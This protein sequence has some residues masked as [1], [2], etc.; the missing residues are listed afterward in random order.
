MQLRI[1]TMVQLYIRST[2][3]LC[4]WGSRLRRWLF[5]YLNVSL[6][7][8][9]DTE[10]ADNMSPWRLI[11]YWLLYSLIDAAF[12]CIGALHCSIYENKSSSAV[13]MI[14]KGLEM[15]IF[16]RDISRVTQR[17]IR[18]Y[19]LHCSFTVWLF[20]VSVCVR[21]RFLQNH[22]FLGSKHAAPL[23]VNGVI[24]SNPGLCEV[25]CN[26]WID[27]WPHSKRNEHSDAWVYYICKVAHNNRWN[28]QQNC[29]S[30]SLRS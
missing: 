12:V 20:F 24:W 2:S 1:F 21:S 11:V 6:L 30:V 23:C 26:Y 15:C 17:Q 7:L 14:N 10:S 13:W 5:I 19:F 22:T 9:S 16:S 4:C 18:R 28:N 27:S 29:Y 3:S 25:S 8:I